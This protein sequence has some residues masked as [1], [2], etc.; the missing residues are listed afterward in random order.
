MS[1][2]QVMQNHGVE[3]FYLT[4]AL[5]IMLSRTRVGGVCRTECTGAELGQSWASANLGVRRGP[6]KT[7]DERN[8]EDTVCLRRRQRDTSSS[9]VHV[10]R[11]PAA[12]IPSL[13]RSYSYTHTCSH[14]LSSPLTSSRSTFV[15]LNKYR[16]NLEV[17]LQFVEQGSA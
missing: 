7:G 14:P 2:N 5:T 4:F 9:L 3:K 8:S 13:Q 10:F 17:S 16:I 15:T 12:V 6:R 11:V 1:Q